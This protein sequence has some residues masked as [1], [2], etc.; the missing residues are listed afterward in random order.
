MVVG[1]EPYGLEVVGSAARAI[2]TKLPESVAAAVLEFVTGDLKRAPQRV[3]RP[4]QREL[5]GLWSARRGAYRVVYEIDDA[6]RVVRVV[7]VDHRSAVYR[8]KTRR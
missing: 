2:A 4:L 5:A 8:R 3:G 6:I 1:E 7:D